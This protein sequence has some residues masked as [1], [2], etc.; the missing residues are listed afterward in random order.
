MFNPNIIIL[1]SD[2]LSLELLDTSK[3]SGEISFV[4]IWDEEIFKEHFISFWSQAFIYE[5]LSNIEGMRVIDGNSVEVL[6]YLK[7]KYEKSKFFYASR[8]EDRFETNSIEKL[9]IRSRVPKIERLPR[10]FFSFYKKIEKTY[11]AK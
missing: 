8:F 9:E 1:D 7:N 10:G 3:L 11:S 4:F 2:S 6:A 5:A